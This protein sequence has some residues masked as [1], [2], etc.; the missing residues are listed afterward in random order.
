MTAPEELRE[1][2]GGL[3][4]WRIELID[5]DERFRLIQCDR[6]VHEDQFV[7][8]YMSEE[9]ENGR[10]L[11]ELIAVYHTSVVRSVVQMERRGDG[12]NVQR[13]ND[14]AGNRLARRA[15]RDQA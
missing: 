7:S 10:K 13:P 4:V 5:D 11:P 9:T 2:Q 3:R 1:K 8:F 6:M 12:A 15:R 14:S